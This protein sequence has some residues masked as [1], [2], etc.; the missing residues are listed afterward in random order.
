MRVRTATL[1][2]QSTALGWAPGRSCTVSIDRPEASGGQGLG[3]NGGELLFLAIAGCYSNDVFREAARL[4]IVVHRVEI[5]VEGDWGGD[6]VRAQNV[7]Y[8]VRVAGDA[9]EEAL[10]EL[11]VHTDRVAEIPNS[12]RHGAEV[13]LREVVV[14]SSRVEMRAGSRHDD[15]G[16]MG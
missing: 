16:R 1:P 10:R 11:L 3:F 12:L 14:E 7:S 15:E 13:T 4:G 9:T 2:G 5:E 6:P 8:A